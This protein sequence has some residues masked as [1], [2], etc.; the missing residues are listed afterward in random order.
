MPHEHEIVAEQVKVGVEKLL[1]G[2]MSAEDFETFVK[3]SNE[4]LDALAAEKRSA[5][6]WSRYNS[7]CYY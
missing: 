4:K 5:E 2:E 7:T 1:A 3:E 6:F